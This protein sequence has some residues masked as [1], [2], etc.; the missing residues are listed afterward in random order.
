MP[1]GFDQRQSGGDVAQ[2]PSANQPVVNHAP[3]GGGGSSSSARAGAFA[4]PHVD[5][6]I[7]AGRQLGQGYLTDR[8]VMQQYANRRE[9]ALGAM[10]TPEERLRVMSQLTQNNPD[11][12]GATSVLAAALYGGGGQGVQAL[13]DQS[14]RSHAGDREFGDRRQML[15]EIR[16]RA[17]AGTLTNM[18]LSF[19]QNQTHGDMMDLQQRMVNDP[20]SGFSPQARAELQQRLAD[21]ENG[22]NPLVLQQ[23]IGQNPQMAQMFRERGMNMKMIDP[24]GRGDLYHYVLDINENNQRQIFDPASRRSGGQVITD[25]NQQRLYDTTRH[26]DFAHAAD[27]PAPAPPPPTPTPAPPPVQTASG[28]ARASEFHWYNPLTWF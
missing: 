3:G 26:I 19:M 11:Q 1:G 7:A 17:Q 22:V 10:N 15:E 20:S 23:F 2:V 9:V 24:N 25:P 21:G 13:I 28:S 12:C 14:E 5:P 6:E 4:A 8:Q 27:F 16:A 18:D